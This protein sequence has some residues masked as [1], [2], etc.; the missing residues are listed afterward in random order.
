MSQIAQIYPWSLRISFALSCD[1]L[2]FNWC[3]HNKQKLSSRIFAF[4]D[5]V[6]KRSKG[7]LTLCCLIRLPVR[8]RRS[9]VKMFRLFFVLALA[10]FLSSFAISQKKSDNQV[11]DLP[12][13]SF[14]LNQNNLN[15]VSLQVLFIS[16]C[17]FQLSTTR[18][19]VAFLK[20]YSSQDVL[21]KM[22]LQ[23]LRILIITD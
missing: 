3:N 10:F 17:P 16:N 19:C 14:I 21:C 2:A 18:N 4:Q 20:V 11:N 23:N 1:S 7:F 22:Y 5:N 8:I 9:S 13:F 6:N 15:R 12:I